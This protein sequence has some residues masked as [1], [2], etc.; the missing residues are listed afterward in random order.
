MKSQVRFSQN[1]AIE[2]SHLMQDYSEFV[3]S[4]ESKEAG[5]KAE[6][7]NVEEEADIEEAIRRS[8]E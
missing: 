7:V 5:P 2:F 4:E 1:L 8:L 6:D 3:E